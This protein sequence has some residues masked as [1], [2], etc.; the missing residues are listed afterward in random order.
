MQEKKLQ[1]KENTIS[2]LKKIKQKIFFLL[3]LNHHPVI[4]VYNGFGNKEKVIV[5][6]HVL[7][8]SPY[9]RVSYRK[10]R[11]INLFSMIRM[12]MVLPYANAKILVEW[13]GEFYPSHSEKDGFFRVEIS[14]D[15]IPEEGWHAVS[16]KLDEKKY[17]ARKISGTGSIYIPFGSQNGYI[18]DIDDTFLISYSARLRRRLYTLFTKNAHSRMPFEGV[19]NHYQLLASSGQEGKNSNPFFYVSGSEWNLYN[20]LV[21]FARK[22]EMPRGVFLL[23]QIKN[24]KGI[25]SSGQKDLRTKFMRI[26]RIIEAY[27]HLKFILLGDDSQQDPAIYL[28]IVQHFPDKIIAVYM[29]NIHEKNT[30][31]V[32]LII[33]EMESKGIACCYFKHSADAVLHSKRTGLIL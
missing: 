8:L 23:S 11:V 10:N 5:L 20:F 14:P 2:F 22:N 26:V 27:P 33:K 30:E 1:H 19:V 3:R 17:H 16:V 12:F 25:F 31:K 28:S 32:K 18:S 9:P 24:I 4:K 13:E 21:E 29:R 6:G 7:K 15:I